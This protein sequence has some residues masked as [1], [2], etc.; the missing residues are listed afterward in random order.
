MS[1]QKK[2][3]RLK[4]KEKRC[5]CCGKKF[6]PRKP[7]DYICSAQCFYDYGMKQLAKKKKADWQ[8]EKKQM[9]ERIAT[10]GDYE[11]ILQTEINTIIRLIDKG[12]N[13]ISCNM[14]LQNK[15]LYAGHFHAVGGNK[16]LRYNLHN[17][18][19]QCFKCNG[20]NGGEPV[21][22]LEGLEREYGAEYAEFV[23]YGIRRRY[24]I[25]KWTVEDIKEWTMIARLIIKE[26]KGLENNY[27]AQERIELR[28]EYNFR[29][30]IYK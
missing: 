19:R 12:C 3:I 22:Y 27:T 21:K 17:I 18:A 5:K 26:L 20:H 24:V 29:L 1:S 7:L 23:H 28:T 10:M 8:V 6:T 11:K 4:F 2:P 25:M 30:K 16:S 9:K 14:G 15:M 13:C